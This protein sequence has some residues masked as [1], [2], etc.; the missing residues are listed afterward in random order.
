MKKKGNAAKKRGNGNFETH[1]KIEF[2]FF[3]F[4]CAENFLSVK[5]KIPR[6]KNKTMKTLK[7]LKK[8]KQFF[9]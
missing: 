8:S 9:F 7:R 4:F 1:K 3:F 6:R 5:K 2:F